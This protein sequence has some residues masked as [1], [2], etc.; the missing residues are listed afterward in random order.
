MKIVRLMVGSWKDYETKTCRE[1]EMWMLNPGNRHQRWSGKNG[2]R[3]S[4]SPGTSRSFRHVPGAESRAA[5]AR[6]PELRGQ[7]R[8]LPSQGSWPSHLT[9][10][11]RCDVLYPVCS[12]KRVCW[13]V[14]ST[15]RPL[16]I[17]FRQRD[18][19]T[20]VCVHR[21]CDAP[22]LNVN[23]PLPP[24]TWGVWNLTGRN[25]L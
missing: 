24:G 9:L 2:T 13:Q 18:V 19:R 4:G 14:P 21:N 22:N 15:K 20:C 5:R 3:S 7:G 6:Q 23:N 25:K 17:S 12:W 1:E 11:P 10:E 8:A 16:K